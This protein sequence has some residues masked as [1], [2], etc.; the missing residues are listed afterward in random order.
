MNL[1]KDIR[2][3]IEAIVKSHYATVSSSMIQ[4]LVN[5]F[6]QSKDSLQVNPTSHHYMTDQRTTGTDTSK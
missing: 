6:Q 5:L 1:Q 3:E 2:Q 4:E